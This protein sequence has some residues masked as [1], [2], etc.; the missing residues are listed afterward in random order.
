MTVQAQVKVRLALTR[1]QAQAYEGASER[2]RSLQSQHEQ[3][4]FA[5][6]Q[7]LLQVACQQALSYSGNNPRARSEYCVD[8]KSK[9]DAIPQQ[10]EASALKFMGYR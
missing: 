8:Q 3:S 9:E 4:A 7:A 5:G 6:A 1:E 10:E 2:L